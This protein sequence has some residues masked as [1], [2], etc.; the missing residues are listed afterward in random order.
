MKYY[1]VIEFACATH[2]NVGRTSDMRLDSRLFTPDLRMNA[3][4]RLSYRWYSQLLC[5]WLLMN[6]VEK[7]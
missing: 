2:S 1:Y 5:N 4:H 6:Q 7:P 3:Q